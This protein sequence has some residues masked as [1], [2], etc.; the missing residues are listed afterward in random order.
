MARKKKILSPT[1]SELIEPVFKALV[2]LDGSGSN[3]EICETIIR[4]LQ[5]PDSVVDEPHKGAASQRTELEYQLAWARTYLKKYGAISNSSRGVWMITPEFADKKDIDAK[6]VIKSWTDRRKNENN[7]ENSVPPELEDDNPENDGME[8]PEELEP[9]RTELAETL[10]TMNPFAFERLAQLLLRE[11]GF[12]QVIVTKKTGDGGIDGTG[13]LRINGIFS[14]NVAFQCKRYSGSVSAG[15]IR[16][17][18][19]SL[20]TD[21]EKGVFI[22]TGTFTRAAKEEASNAGKQQIDL[23]DGEEFINKLLEYHLGVREKTIYEVDKE[24][25]QKI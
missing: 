22:T 13:K 3:D 4:M 9:W 12:S 5:L 8:V 21:I 2:E 24:F 17:F 15:D 10:H 1:Y 18:R 25:F 19:G 14:F 23:M 7:K 6:A 11:C 20:T 16:D